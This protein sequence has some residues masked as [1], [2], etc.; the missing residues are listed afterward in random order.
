MISHNACL[1]LSPQFSLSDAPFLELQGGDQSPLLAVGVGSDWGL[2]QG[3][4]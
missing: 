4:T 3:L 2:A 1:L